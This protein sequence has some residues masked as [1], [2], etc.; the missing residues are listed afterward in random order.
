MASGGR[1]ERLVRGST[2]FYDAL[3]GLYPEDYKEEYAR[4]MSLAF[5]DLLRE[6]HARRGVKGLTLAWLNELPA[7]LVGAMSERS[8][9]MARTALGARRFVSLKLLMTVNALLLIVLGVA[10]FMRPLELMVAYGL[11]GDYSQTPPGG[12]PYE[13][14]R[15]TLPVKLLSQTLGGILAGFGFVVWAATLAAG[16]A[17]RTA[18]AL[19][20]AAA[21]CLMALN[22]W[23]NAVQYPT[24]LGQ[25]SL[26]VS[27]VF[28][29]AYAGSFV[30]IAYR[31][32]PG[33]GPEAKRYKRTDARRHSVRQTTGRPR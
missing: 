20:L 12:A 31:T 17:A 24:V 19:A 25:V 13:A 33:T 29:V 14:W 16:P 11:I 6:E 22:F 5:G 27:L 9:T 3:V 8:V 10:L 30:A 4:E 7:L 26:W 23:V 2:R 32:E 1:G 28:V 18:L 15:D 21:H